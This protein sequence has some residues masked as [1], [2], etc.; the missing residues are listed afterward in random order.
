MGTFVEVRVWGSRDDQEKIIEETFEFASAFEGKFNIFST[1]SEINHLNL[2]KK[3]K[4]SP[5]LYHVLDLS[6]KISVMTDGEFDVTIA[7][8]LKYGGFYEEM[9]ESIRNMIPDRYEKGDWKNITLVSP[10]HVSLDGGV[11][12]DASGI[13]KGYIVDQMAAFLADKKMVYFLINAA[14]KNGYR[15]LILFIR[16]PM[17]IW[18]I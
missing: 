4:V 7:P 18:T 15:N 3:A 8:M 9:P 13:A 2:K 17:P 10:D 6:K 11:W 1:R 5:E 12:V 16:L 14:L